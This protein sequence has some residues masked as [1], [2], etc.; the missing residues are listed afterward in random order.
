MPSPKR[1]LI[2]ILTLVI[3]TLLV[4]ACQ[5]SN[6]AL[7]T[8]VP[9]Y[10]T[11]IPQPV[12]TSFMLPE[13][14][15][16]LT[17]GPSAED[18]LQLIDE[19]LNQSVQASIAYNAPKDMRL[20]ETAAIELLLNPSLSEPELV[21]Q[22]QE[23][24]YVFSGQVEITPRM[25]AEIFSPDKDAFVIQAIH[26][27]PVQVISAADTT[28]WSWY[29]TAKKG[30]TQ[31]LTIVL[32]RL[33]KY[34][35]E[36]YWREV[37]TYRSDITVKVTLLD[38]LQ[39]TGWYWVA[40]I[41]VIALLVFAFW[42]WTNQNNKNDK[43]TST[44]RPKPIP[45]SVSTLT[46]HAF[47]SYRRADSSDIVGRIYD[48]LVEAFG[49]EPIFKDVDDIPLGVDFKEFLDQKVSECT[50]LLAVIGDRWVDLKDAAGSRRLDDPN[51]FV[52][53][54]IESALARDIPVIP[55]LVRGASMPKAGELPASLQKLVYKNGIP[56]RPDPDF[57]HDMDRLVAALETYLR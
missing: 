51:D 46:G 9:A 50:V 25:K 45:D 34:E 17:G 21:E 1:A 4:A 15:V 41:L 38:K 6:Y 12:P 24:G 35:G 49:D 5:L 47:I 27:Q 23:S 36:E 40:G 37:E 29:I 28:A 52:R 16:P 31:K 2:P 56:I 13:L 44:L 54:E 11:P 43:R 22:V 18:E 20:N 48:H 7:S 53:I 10:E 55:L 8:P 30:G 33:I 14:I 26:A 39:S 32:Y 3:T 57:R 42:R 19:T